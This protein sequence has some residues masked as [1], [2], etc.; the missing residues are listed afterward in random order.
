MGLFIKVMVLVLAIGI[1]LVWLDRKAGRLRAEDLEY[2]RRDGT[3]RPE[4]GQ[5]WE[6]SD[7]PE[8]A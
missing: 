6:D 4:P 2:V 3:P 8:A 7:P 5:K 1:F